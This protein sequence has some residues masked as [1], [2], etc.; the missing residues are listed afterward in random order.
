[1]NLTC[2]IQFRRAIHDITTPFDVA[3]C[4]PARLNETHAPGIRRV[5]CRGVR[6]VQA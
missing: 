4:Q 6:A 5:S 1:M 2:D 3:P